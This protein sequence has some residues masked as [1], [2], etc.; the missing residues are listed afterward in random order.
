MFGWALGRCHFRNVLSGLSCFLGGGELF[1]YLGVIHLRRGV[2]TE[3]M[4]AVAEA[5][6]RLR[7]EF[8]RRL[9]LQEVAEF[10][11]GF[12]KVAEFKLA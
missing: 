10:E 6:L 7:Q 9:R 3:A 4:K 8:F 2:V 5:K 12:L 11:R 1:D